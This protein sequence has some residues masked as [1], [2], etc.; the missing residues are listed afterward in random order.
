MIRIFRLASF[1]RSWITTTT[2]IMGAL[3]A[4]GQPGVAM[5]EETPK[6][7]FIIVDG[8]PADVLE[9]TPTPNFDD[10]SRAGGYTRAWLGGEAGGETESPTVSAVGYMSL[11]TGTWSNKHNVY[12]NDVNE[13]NYDY[14]DIFRIAK[15]HDP[16]LHTAI[17]STWIDNR[18]KLLGDGLPEAGGHKL[19]YSFDG[20]E[21]DTERF[22]HDPN[23]DYIKNID[24]MVV[25]ETA[26]YVRDVGPDLSWVY[27]EYTDD[28]GHRYGDG[29]EMTAAVQL[30]DER[31]G[32][33]W[34]AVQARQQSH[35]EEWLLI[36]TTDHGRGAET[37]KDHGGHSERERTIWIA[38]NSNKLNARFSEMPAVVD[39]L[40]S[41]AAHMGLGMPADVRAALD[42]QSFI[43]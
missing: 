17:F 2:I 4:A 15:S 35:E 19:N 23:G 43:D 18:T 42:G 41:I 10:I 14:W 27:L 7:I 34:N 3:V 1:S 8:I 31:I 36:V 33:I 13:P 25:A 32:E 26:R 24:A 16:S 30:M 39:I 9:S 40:P 21:L 38:T 12:D 5:A 20:F 28:I 11:V 37:G 6:A 22:P 29:P